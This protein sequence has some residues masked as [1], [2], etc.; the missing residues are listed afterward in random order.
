MNNYSIFYCEDDSTSNAVIESFLLELKLKYSNI[1][2]KKISFDEII[3]NKLFDSVQP[4][5]LILDLLDDK[6]KKLKGLT[7]LT[8]IKSSH[9]N[10]TTIVYSLGKTGSKDDVNLVQLKREYPFVLESIKKFNDVTDE[11]LRDI[12]EVQLLNRLPA[13]YCLKNENDLIIQLQ[14]SSIGRI[15]LNQII[16]QIKEKLGIKENIVLERMISGYSGAILF[17]FKYQNTIYILKL[18]NEISKLETEFDNSQKYYYKF[19]TKFF[20][21]INPEK[22]YST[23]KKTLGILIKLIEGGKTLFEVINIAGDFSNEIEPLLIDIFTNDYSLKKH[24][25]VQRDLSQSWTFIF[26]KFSDNKFSIIESSYEELK[27]LFHDFDFNFSNLKNLV[28]YHTW[29][30]LDKN[31]L[32]KVSPFVL[33]HG[34]LH[35][36]NILIQNKHPFLIDTGGIGYN[37]WCLDICRLVI[38]L[39]V[40]GFD[41]DKKD[42]YDINKIS[43]NV[44]IAKHI[45]E[46]VTIPLDGKNDNFI[47]TIN[48][49]LLHCID[50]YGDLYCKFEFQLGLMKEFLQASCRVGTLSHNKRA[51]SLISAYECMLIANQTIASS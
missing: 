27:P 44:K 16:N 4:D 13:Q 8:L 38:D 39:F 9:K 6:E 31:K 14:I 45:I 28:L 17:K 37:Y 29:A 11:E 49:L 34:D 43:N 33:C 26:N 47:K 23:N 18:S 25:L 50:I 42:F 15:D 3:I 21:Y 36:K 48:W 7:V 5:L 46:Q 35:S 41:Y 20:N 19:P 24:Y 22:Y 1:T 10:I 40:K 32:E 12:I 51:I 2:Y 30:N